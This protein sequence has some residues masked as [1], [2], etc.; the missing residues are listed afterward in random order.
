MA[1][2][3]NDVN[4][5]V[6]VGFAAGPVTTGVAWTDITKYAKQVRTQRGRSH[7]LDNI[8]AG[9]LTV[10]LDN[11][12]RRF[13]PSDTGSP[14]G[15]TNLIPMKP[16]RVKAVHSGT[17]YQL[18]RGLVE[19]WPQQW[20]EGGLAQQTP[21][22]AVDGLKVFAF[23]ETGT[24]HPQETAGA[25]IK[26]LLQEGAWSTAKMSLQAGSS[27]KAHTGTCTHILSEVGTVAD[28]DGGLFFMSPAGV[29][30][31]QSS[32][33]RAAQTIT[34]TFGEQELGYHELVLGYDEQQIWNDVTV[35][36]EGNVSAHTTH[37]TASI[38]K[39]GRRK[40]KQFDMLMTSSVQ[41][42]ARAAS[43]IARYKDPHLRVERMT[44]APRADP[45]NL[46]PVVL[47]AELSDK[48][49]VRRRYASG[50]PTVIEGFVESV[51]HSF[52]VEKE[53]NTSFVV[54]PS[55]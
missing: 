55:T 4:V 54:S 33:Y 38:D 34:S 2:F 32:T 27:V 13:D 22:R 46:W 17:T 5:F 15:S 10:D 3:D 42:D 16:I 51:S 53:W 14:Y 52:N 50:N 23:H 28:S 21:L 30:T 19:S 26:A 45:A 12:D 48:Y 36:F 49:R 7:E 20:E 8:Q 31:Y 40:L 24:T 39:Y 37:S 41:A 11:R 18:W 9:T 47:G 43:L 35:M 6:E 44:V 29:A 25:R 1:I